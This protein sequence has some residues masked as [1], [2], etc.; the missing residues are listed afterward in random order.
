MKISK[1]IKK[2]LA[3][4]LTG[5]MVASGIVWLEVDRDIPLNRS[6][7]NFENVLFDFLSSTKYSTEDLGL[8]DTSSIKTNTT[9]E[10][11]IVLVDI[12]ESSMDILGS[13]NLWPRSY[14]AK[15]VD[16]LTKG[17]ASSIT[18]DILFKNADWG[19]TDAQAAIRVLKNVDSTIQWDKLA[20]KIK[21]GYNYDSMLVKS[22][23]NAG[24]VISGAT[25][26][27]RDE[28]FN[29]PKYW[30]SKSTKEWQEEIGLH[31]TFPIPTNLAVDHNINK[32]ILDNT[33]S[34]FSK[35]SYK[36]GLV[37]V[38]PDN[39][40][41]HRSEPLLYTYPNPETTPGVTPRF[42]P[43]IA[44]QTSLLLMGIDPKD[45]IIIPEEKIII[46]QPFGLYKD[47]LGIIQTTYPN[48]SWPS[49]RSMIQQKE[50]ILKLSNPDIA[51]SLKRNIDLST[52]VLIYHNKDG[53]SADILDAQTLTPE[54]LKTI[55]EF[56][57]FKQIILDAK[58]AAKA[59]LIQNPE[60]EQQLEGYIE[61]AAVSDELLLGYSLD[62]NKM[63]L[64]EFD[65]EE[66]DEEIYFDDYT[67]NVLDY[68]KLDIQRLA[69][70]QQ[71]YLSIPADISIQAGDLY[72][73]IIILQDDVILDIINWEETTLIK[74]LN[75]GDT[76]RFGD[77]I[78]IPIWGKDMRMFINFL[79]LKQSKDNETFKHISYSD[80][81]RNRIQV[82]AFQGKVFMLG[83]TAPA[84]F[85]MVAAPGVP[86]YPGVDIHLNMMENIL[87]NNFLHKA[88]SKDIIFI[89]IAFAFIAAL[90]ATYLSP[91][92]ASILIIII[93]AIY[94]IFNF[95][96]FNLGVYFGIVRPQV[97]LMSAF[98]FSLIY[99]L[100]FEE[101]A[102]RQAVQAFKNY[103]SPE[104]I[105][106]MLESD[107]EPTL[108]GEESF[109][110]AYFTD[111]ASFSTFSEKIGSPTRLVELLNEYLTDMTNIL[112]AE[113]GTLD[114]YEGDAIIAFFGAP[115]P[116]A[117][118]AYASCISA[119]NMQNK[120]GDLRAK[121]ESEGDKWPQIV[122]HMRMRIGI[123]SGQIVTGNM[124]SKMHMNYTMMGDAVNLAARLESGAKQYGVFNMCSKTTID[125]AHAQVPEGA[126][127]LLTREIDR[128]KV[129]GK[130]EPV[131]IYELLNFENEATDIETEL[132]KLFAQAIDKYRACQWDEAE[133]IFIKCLDLEIYHPDRAPGCKTTPS[134]V[135][136]KRC[137]EYAQ[138]PP[139][140]QGESWDGVYTATEK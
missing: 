55:T 38:T 11:R 93:S 108:G 20:S 47:S 37:N 21:A 101:R 87:T 50:S 3:F 13:Y 65:G 4:V 91:I 28:Y 39:D 133:A 23:Q 136:I 135:F 110:T 18:F 130:S 86:N 112:T 51:D 82:A 33:F 89:I 25:V 113:G 102:K 66:L 100:M 56:P 1:R 126:T 125:A 63:A 59:Q 5:L 73:S 114:K 137:Q 95:H 52:S 6:L 121:W 60:P 30:V 35:S 15:V 119:I 96:Y 27:N 104:L 41:V 109:L 43:V 92:W 58:K 69:L 117:N 29:D 26:G 138:N 53:V 48:L 7:D 49:I 111:I 2:V 46:G 81:I 120:L 83:S 127:K 106:Q 88:D 44:L 77:S 14:H 80:L 132:V 72:S 34:N 98:G 124:G 123:N 62:E 116:L 71:K 19:A 79:D 107:E 45:I 75:Q 17:G 9:L 61:V 70:G 84:L 140:N 76:L 115:V 57:N 94:F 105:D 22:V 134:H 122:H 12:D 85:D 68:F 10:K 131:E 31:S 74:R 64:M 103:I 24:N 36:M 90:I 16:Q 40:G 67:L 32:E 97:A 128:V 42:Y 118:N 139:V 129:V 78:E 8:Q 99:K 54:M